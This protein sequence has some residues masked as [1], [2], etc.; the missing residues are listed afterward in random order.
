MAKEALK[1]IED[2][3]NCS[4]CLDT[5]TD[6]KLLQCNH[7]YCRKCL[8]PLVDRD[9]QGQLGLTCPTCRQ[10][11][12]IPDRGVAGLSPAFHINRLLEIKDSLQKP[13]REGADEGAMEASATESSASSSVA[14]RCLEHPGEESKLY[15]ETCEELVCYICAI[16][17]G[18]H[19]SH[20]YEDLKGA[21]QKYREEITSSIE[22]LE[23]REVKAKKTQA[24]IDTRCG[25]IS[26][27][28]TATKDEVQITFRR[29]QEVLNARETEILD[30]LDQMTQEKQKSLT[31]QR[32]Q[33]EST[34]SQLNSCL[35]LM[36]EVL[37][38]GSDRDVLAMKTYT[39]D[40]VKELTTLRLETSEPRVKADIAFSVSNDITPECQKLGKLSQGQISQVGAMGDNMILPV[41]KNM[42]PEYV[43]CEQLPI[44]RQKRQGGKFGQ[45]I[46]IPVLTIGRVAGPWGI[47]VNGRKEIFISECDKNCVSVFSPSGEKVRSFGT[48]GSGQGEFQRPRGIA[49]DGEENIL[50]V[51][52]LNYRIQKFTSGGHFLST[53]GTKGSG[54]PQFSWPTDIAF[55]PTNNKVY[56]VDNDSNCIQILNSDLSSSGSFGTAGNDMGQFCSPLGIAC[57]NGG[58]V[59]VVDT[60]NN[61]IQVFTAEGKFLRMFGKHGIGG[62]GELKLPY[63][64]A[65]DPSGIVYVS[66]HMRQRIFVYTSKGQFMTCFGRKG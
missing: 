18:K 47:A 12:P 20:E 33:T 64:V 56:V 2:Q 6:P 1:K 55:N 45:N 42:A 40:Q 31:T 54:V 8:V 10:V 41:S 5:F 25:E 17:G 26:N 22:L 37:R 58:K 49:I 14:Q 4:I 32:G 16:E 63:G 23:K 15:C 44:E 21:A 9:Q 7:I 13:H 39:R 51:D 11:T 28:Q 46:G 38:T 66:E 36:R 62:R 35:H 34:L 50:V 29:L 65:L 52:S 61:R 19:Q 57:G 53:V 3:V 60:L 59:Y 43:N 48:R 30:Q 24:Q 27:Q